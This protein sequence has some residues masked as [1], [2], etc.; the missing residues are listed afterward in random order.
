MV[1]HFDLYLKKMNSSFL[2]GIFLISGFFVKNENDFA[3]VK[4][5]IIFLIISFFLPG[6]SWLISSTVSMTFPFLLALNFKE[7]L[8]ELRGNQFLFILCLVWF[9]SGGVF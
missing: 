1:L 4:S 5:S 3:K 2:I 8:S 9:I 6:K 7:L